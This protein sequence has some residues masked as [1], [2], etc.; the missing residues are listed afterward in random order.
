MTATPE[1]DKRDRN[2]VDIAG[3][4]MRVDAD[5][6]FGGAEKTGPAFAVCDHGWSGDLSI[7]GCFPTHLQAANWV[8]SISERNFCDY[9]VVWREGDRLRL[10][11]YGR[12]AA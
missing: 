12:D 3:R 7:I 1:I 11:R 2:L 10:D 4:L 9:Y 5:A 6:L 8:R